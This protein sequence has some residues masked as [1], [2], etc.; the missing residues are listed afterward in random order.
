MP[1]LTPVSRR[2]FIERL[3]ELGFEDL[4]PGENTLKCDGEI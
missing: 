4:L 3:H 1:K 2:K